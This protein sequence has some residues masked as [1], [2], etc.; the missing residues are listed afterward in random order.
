[1]PHQLA[2]CSLLAEGDQN[3]LALHQAHVTLKGLQGA[4][5]PALEAEVHG[6]MSSVSARLGMRAGAARA[7]REAT[8]L[9][10]EAGDVEGNQRWLDAALATDVNL[11]RGEARRANA[12]LFAPFRVD[13]QPRWQHRARS[14][15][16]APSPR[17]V[18][19][20]G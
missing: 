7:L 8:R 20:P 17:G 15:G 3:E 1:M 5:L 2:I 16:A 19:E 13:P 4:G 14:S 9:S 6:L 10:A 12:S 18:N 11:D